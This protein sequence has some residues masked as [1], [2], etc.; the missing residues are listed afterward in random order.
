MSLIERAVGKL[1]SAP[2]PRPLPELAAER[3]REMQPH[4][5]PAPQAPPVA[6]A[7]VA[8]APIVTA[9]GV[10]VAGSDAQGEPTAPTSVR[11]DL[12]SLVARGFVSAHGQP[13]AIGQQFRVI[14]RPLIAN[15][16]GEGF[17]E[18]R[19]GRRV[20]V[21]SAL[22][23][24]GKSF[25]AVNLAMSIAAERDYQVL[26]VDADV[27]RPSLPRELGLAPGPGLMDWLIDGAPDLRRLVR[28]TNVEK[29]SILQAG[30]AH[31]HATELLASSSMRTLLDT[32]TT[33]YPDRLMIFDSPPLLVTTESQV[34]ATHMG[35]IV[36]VVESGR[37]PRD[38]VKQALAAVENC[39]VVGV[40][41]NKSRETRRDGYY[42]YGAYGNE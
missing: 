41:L 4:P 40:V 34:L 32:L 18:H 26:L 24:E 29:L 13:T 42:G 2:A 5:D 17:A 11:I 33:L 25:C 31:P 6:E 16:F 10:P 36:M 8:T 12:Q 38:A 19:N 39:G 23:N 37:T 27:L 28:P 30:R 20:M 9:P 3:A 35:Q 14:K 21:T 7:P 22:P 15:A 1:T